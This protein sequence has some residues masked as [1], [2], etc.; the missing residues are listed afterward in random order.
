MSGSGMSA[1]GKSNVSPDLT[2]R[3]RPR[4]VRRFSRKA[5]LA[6]AAG[7]GVLLFGALAVALQSPTYDE[8]PS[9]ELYNVTHK[10]MADGLEH[11]PKSYAELKPV[12]GPPLPGDL[13]A[14]YLVKTEAVEQPPV[15]A[16]AMVSP[17]PARLASD[18][19]PPQ[20]R[21]QSAAPT[22]TA[23]TANS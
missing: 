15:Q 18:S 9:S 20:A 14:A 2:I 3:A 12:L 6:G 10:P 22:Y 4:A 16:P 1:S 21:P 11:L 13:G 8:E 17:R 23:P 19:A 5:L 7:L